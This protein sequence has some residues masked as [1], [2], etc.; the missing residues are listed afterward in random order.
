M[1]LSGGVERLEATEQL[2]EPAAEPTLVE[3]RARRPADA[4][5]ARTVRDRRRGRLVRRPVGVRGAIRLHGL[6]RR[7]LVG[8]RTLHPREEVRA[9]D[10]L[11]GEEPRAGLL[12]E[13]AERD[14]VRVLDVLDGAELA[15]EAE[16]RLRREPPEALQRDADAVLP[17][18]R[19]VDDARAAVADAS[20]DG[21]ARRSREGVRFLLRGQAPPILSARQL[22]LR[23][24]GMALVEEERAPEDLRERG[25]G[26]R[27]EL[28]AG[29]LAVDR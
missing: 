12:E 5:G 16:D 21:E 3:H 1:H 15:L 23:L 20:H 2:R 4:R 6:R 11:H 22:D 25:A 26:L 13:L 24:A 19:L 29:F 14:Q 18:A 17:V 10:V 28:G 27:G 9:L 7:A 8:R